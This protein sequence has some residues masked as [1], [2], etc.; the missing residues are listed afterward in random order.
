MGTGARP[1]GPQAQGARPQ[2]LWPPGGSPSGL[3]LPNFF[4]YSKIIPHKF[5]GLLVMGRISL[6][7]L[8]LSGPEFEVPS[9]SLFK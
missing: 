3:S 7:D 4:I 9:F 6:S 8:L 1:G 2:G 5:L